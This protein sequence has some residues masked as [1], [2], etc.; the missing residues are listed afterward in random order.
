MMIMIMIM[1]M[2]GLDYTPSELLNELGRPAK[3]AIDITCQCMRL[4]LGCGCE[5][6]LAGLRVGE[7]DGDVH[8]AATVLGAVQ[9]VDM[10]ERKIPLAAFH[11]VSSA[12]SEWYTMGGRE[13][14]GLPLVGVETDARGPRIRDDGDEL[15]TTPA[16]QHNPL[17]C[18]R[19]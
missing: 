8:T 11:E 13:F 5:D 19:V 4:P 17:N 16:S 15:V 12:C 7:L 1:I 10:I 14:A 18:P 9:T 3:Q 2:M 6:A